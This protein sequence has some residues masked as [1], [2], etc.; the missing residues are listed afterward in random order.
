LIGPAEAGAA[1][2]LANMLRN[3]GGAVGT[4]T[5]ATVLTRRE[6]FDS[7]IIGLSRFRPTRRAISC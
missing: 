7:N 2:G 3:L 6:Q 5:R 4:A 1:S